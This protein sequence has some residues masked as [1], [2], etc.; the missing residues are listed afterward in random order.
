MTY[1]YY[2]QRRVRKL[3]RKSKRNLIFTIILIAIILYATINWVLPSFI[4]GIAFIQNFIKP[5][6]KTQTPNKNIVLAPP[7]LNIPYEATNS[8]QITISGFGQPDSKVTLFIDD[9]AK[10][11]VNVSGDGSF[12]IENV[13]LNFGT[14]NIYAK[15]VNEEG[16][17][18][19]PSKTIRLIFDNEKPLLEV[20]EP[21]DGKNIQGE[22]KS[23]ISGKTE[24]NASVF[25]NNNQ[26]IVDKEGKFES[27]QTLNDGENIF[28]IKAQDTAGNF[29]EISRKVI[30]QP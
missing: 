15:T 25:I 24:N 1:R 6:T 30:F 2:S 11:T 13:S 22:R 8:S 20:F 23:K 14:N 28:T 4:S 21:E 5:Q 12:L 9:Q 16:L 3:S 10:D 26:I 19:L 18:S 29:L 27:T 7:V 17:E